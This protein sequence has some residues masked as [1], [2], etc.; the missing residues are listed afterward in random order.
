MAGAAELG[1]AALLL[2]CPCST[3][4][5]AATPAGAPWAAVA[6]WGWAQSPLG[7][8]GMEHF[9]AYAVGLEGDSSPHCMLLLMPPSAPAGARG[10]CQGSPDVLILKAL[11][12][13]DMALPHVTGRQ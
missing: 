9:V 8:Q 5:P 11:G 3:H 12:P 10:P 4:P 1:T 7:W 6:V 13:G 2:L